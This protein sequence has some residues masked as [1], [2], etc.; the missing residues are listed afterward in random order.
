M[1]TSLTPLRLYQS[2]VLAEWI[3][4]TGHMNETYYVLYASRANDELIDMIGMD[5]AF[6]RKHRRT[7]CT[8]ET[9]VIYL[10][11]V[12]K[13]DVVEVESQLLSLDEKK[14]RIFHKLIHGRDRELL[15][16]VEMMMLHVD[17]TG[18]RAAPFEDGPMRA[19]SKIHDDHKLMPMPSRAG[20]GIG[21]E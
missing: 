8:T 2:P 11:E 21:R 5:E 19:L 4:H 14:F 9:H 15:G 18:P 3:G 13:G 17:S 7:I 20:R 6:R 10:R 16:T 1:S 12:G